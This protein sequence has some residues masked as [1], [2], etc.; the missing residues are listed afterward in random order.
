MYGLLIPDRESTGLRIRLREE[1][2]CGLAILRAEVPL[3]N[4]CGPKREKRR[5]LKGGELLRKQGVRE[6]LNLPD[7]PFWSVLAQT[8]LRPVDTG[9]LCRATA[10]PLALTVLRLRGWEP[11]RATVTLSGERA[12]KY[13]LRAAEELAGKV[14]RVVIDVPNEGER[15]ARQL[16]WEHGMP[17]LTPGV[18]RA[19]LTLA[20]DPSRTGRGATLLLYGP[21]P[22]LL[23]AEVYAR[24]VEVPEGYP[25]MPL[26]AALRERG[27][28]SDKMLRAGCGAEAK[29]EIFLDNSL[30]NTYNSLDNKNG[31]VSDRTDTT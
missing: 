19:A 30:Q 6:L 3:G 16:Q 2:V 21:R 9:E 26:L 5:L 7:A 22:K 31:S 27:L 8:G 13:L 25:S 15:L 23:G 20:F 12:G 18:V 10:A 11:G 1:T 14:A 4:R 24:G 29:E 28:I 17:V